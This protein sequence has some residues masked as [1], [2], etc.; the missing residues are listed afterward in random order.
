MAIPRRVPQQDHAAASRRVGL[1]NVRQLR[2][3]L[4]ALLAHAHG[5][6]PG[7][8]TR[9]RPALHNRA[10]PV[11]VALRGG[12]LQ[13][14]LSGSFIS[15]VQQAPLCDA[16]LACLGQDCTA[17]VLCAVAAYLWV[18]LWSNLVATGKIEPKLSRKIMHTGSAPLFMLCWPLFSGAPTARLLAGLV[19]MI[20]IVRLYRAGQSPAPGASSAEGGGEDALV[21]AVS[22]SG[23]RS[24]A[25]GGPF[26]YALVLFVCTVAGWRSPAAATAL[27]QMAVGD[28]MADIVG[29]RFGSVRWPFNPRCAHPPL[30]SRRL[31]LAAGADVALV[32]R[33]C[34][35]APPLSTRSKSVAGTSAFVLSSFA[36]SLGMIGLFHAC[37]FNALTPL[38]AAPAVLAVSLGSALVELLPSEMGDD[39]L[40]VPACAWALSALLLAEP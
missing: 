38:A 7:L 17:A 29:R 26:L 31:I 33:T 18:A 15:S 21:G 39:N 5:L 2:L 27:C 20:Q 35:P 19:P 25:L 14:S 34:S 22:R 1:A 32:E 40:T 4:F 16:P 37:G 36:S 3:A 9:A 28:G 12:A 6:Q 24:E 8:H 11:S 10:V 30:A 23:E 13:L